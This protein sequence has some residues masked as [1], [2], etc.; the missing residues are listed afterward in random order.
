MKRH[1]HIKL[2][3][4]LLMLA[5]MLSIFTVSVSAEEKNGGKYLKDVFIAYGTDKTAAEKWLRN[6]GWEPVADLNEGKTSNAPGFKNAVAVLGIRRTSDPNEA[7]T[8]MAVLNM[9]GEYSFDDYESIAAQKKTDIDEFIKTFIPA[10]EEYRENYNGKGS[11][12]GKKRAQLAHDLLNRFFDGDPNGEYAMNDTGKPLG[13]LFLS[14][15]KTEIG[16]DAYNALS[17]EHRLNVVD[18]QQIILESSGP[19]VLIIEQSLALAADTA[20]TSW[21]DRLDGLTGEALVERIEEFAPEVK[22][23]DLAPSAARS[24]LAARFYDY[25]KNLAAEWINIHEDILWFEQYC[26]EHELWQDKTSGKINAK[27][28]EQYF[29]ALKKEDKTRYEKESKKFNDIFLYYYKL[30]DISYSGEW[31]E[32]LYDFFHPEDEQA[33]YSEE[34][35][36]FA[37]LAASL[38]RT[39]CGTG[40]YQAFY[41]VKA[42]CQQRFRDES[43]SSFH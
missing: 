20:E 16:D 24:L 9:K 23:Q 42:R 33:D 2:L 36:F 21:L 38:Q 17:A 19:A 34:Y 29:K 25:T 41:P 27:A 6:N 8:D 5:M 4:V 7:I 1:L 22:G 40:I 35:D 30:K 28:F 37:P 12:G 13:D 32:T 10:M 11:A 3:S 31:G 39:A 43:G 26:D 14:K 15:T 18:F